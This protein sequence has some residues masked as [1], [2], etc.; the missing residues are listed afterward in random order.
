M[1]G[2]EH[3]DRLSFCLKGATV[4]KI[5]QQT[6]ILLNKKAEPRTIDLFPATMLHANSLTEMNSEHSVPSNLVLGG[7]LHLKMVQEHDAEAPGT[8]SDP[9]E[10][11]KYP[12]PAGQYRCR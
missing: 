4:T 8:F 1:K 5:T 10:G 12:Y 9:D 3:G 6:T 11:V 7:W 2:F